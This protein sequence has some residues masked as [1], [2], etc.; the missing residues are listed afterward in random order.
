MVMD[1]VAQRARI[2]RNRY[3][4]A[5]CV[6]FKHLNVAF[7][8]VQSACLLVNGN[9]GCIFYLSIV[10]PFVG[11]STVIKRIVL[12]RTWLAERDEC[13]ASFITS[14]WVKH[15]NVFERTPHDRVILLALWLVNYYERRSSIIS[16]RTRLER[17]THV[18]TGVCMTETDDQSQEPLC[19]KRVPV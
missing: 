12:F 13:S 1:H 7:P 19:W 10:P 6:G 15:G 16:K 11:I 18:I 3:G 8:F 9:S 14:A 17:C 4:Q 5:C 2:L